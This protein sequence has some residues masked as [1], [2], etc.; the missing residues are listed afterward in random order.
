ME[1]HRRG[2]YELIYIKIKRLDW[3]E[4]YGILNTSM[5]D[6]QGNILIVVDHREVLKIWMN[7]IIEIYNRPNRL[8]N[9]QVEPEEEVDA[10]EKGTMK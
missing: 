6:S 5:E 4:N 7:Y 9:L 3:E 1:F 8:E 2:R 10:G